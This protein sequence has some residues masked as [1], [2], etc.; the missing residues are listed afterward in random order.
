MK[1]LVAFLIV[2]SLTGCNFICD[3][4]V[5][6]ESLSPDQVLAVTTFTRDCG[7]TTDFSTITT[8]HKRGSN[9][10]DQDHIV[11]VAKGIHKLQVDWT[12]PRT[13]RIQCFDCLRDQ[14]FRE[15][16]KFGDVDLSYK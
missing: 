16:T 1:L 10:R 2:L 12:A 6:T 8:V 7:A 9:F 14:V 5:A 15:V 11:F 3:D 4:K 13:I